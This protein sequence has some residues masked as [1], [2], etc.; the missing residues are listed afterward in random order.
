[1]WCCLW[2]LGQSVDN[3]SSSQHQGR[4]LGNPGSH[5]DFCLHFFA[6]KCI[7]YKFCHK[8]ETFCKLYGRILRQIQSVCYHNVLVEMVCPNQVISLL[9]WGEYKAN[10]K[11]WY[12]MYGSLLG[13]SFYQQHR[14]IVGAI[15]FVRLENEELLT[16]D[17]KVC[18]AQQAISV[19]I[20]FNVWVDR[21]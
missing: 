5:F 9:G 14:I 15:S 12:A 1:M 21:G 2:G 3:C 18:K 19:E 20:S 10:T 16:S 13:Q 8:L 17:G 11:E 7:F 6:C 4:C